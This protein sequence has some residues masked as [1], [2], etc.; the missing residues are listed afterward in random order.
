MKDLTEGTEEFKTALEEAN[1]KAVELLETY[2]LFGKYSIK[3]GVITIDE[4]ALKELQNAA[5]MKANDAEN[6]SYM[7]KIIANEKQD[8]SKTTNLGRKIGNVVGTGR[9]DDY[10]REIKEKFSNDDLLATAKAL[11]KLRESSE[12]EYKTAMSSDKAFKEMLL[13]LDGVPQ[14]VLDNVDAY[15]ENRSAI[16]EHTQSIYDS[17]KANRFYTEQMYTNLVENK[18]GEKINQMVT[19]K[20]GNVDTTRA[21]Q[22]SNIITK[23]DDK[24]V[25]KMNTDLNNAD[26]KLKD[27]KYKSN[28]ALKKNYGYDIENDKDLVKTYL[29]EIKG[30]TQE[31]L[32]TFTFDDKWGKATVT[33]DQGNNILLDKNDKEMRKALA[34]KKIRGD[35]ETEYTNN[36]DAEKQLNAIGKLTTVTD[37]KLGK[38]FSDAILNALTTDNKKMDFSGVYAELSP[39]E[40]VDWQEAALTDDGKTDSA[41]LLK[42]L[43]IDEATIKAA[44]FE[45]ADQFAQQFAVGLSEYKWDKESALKAAMGAQ[46]DEIEEHELDSE[47]VEE[48]ADHLM[49]I[50][51]ESEE[52][53][54]GLE[55]NAKSAA[56]IATVLARANKGLGNLS[57]GFED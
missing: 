11:N 40:A 10:G 24:A 33:D 56:K 23:T 27:K 29:K 17:E 26:D 28:N 50:A 25:D 30:Y 1:E 53:D 51:K 20:D 45:S 46:S 36:L 16:V 2:N 35:I 32:D 43:G 7:A 42:K 57:E 54:D 49:D 38:G 13:T 44:G 19:D 47:A 18:Y 6:S 15:V 48:Y 41:G 14:V 3:D 5:N 4:D 55:T 12:A 21:A 39:E 52:V 8:I 9:Y 31:E 22:I 34:L 37:S